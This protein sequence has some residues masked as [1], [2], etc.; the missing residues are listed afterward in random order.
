MTSENQQGPSETELLQAWLSSRDVPCPV[1]GY[2]LR[3]IEV[4]NCPECGAKLD[5]RVGSTDLKIG[6]WLVG[7]ISLTLPMGLSGFFAIYGLLMVL[8]GARGG[9]ALVT[10]LIA[11]GILA[12]PFVVYALLLRRLIRRRKEFW[13]KPRK[14]QKVSAVLY[15][16]AGSAPVTIPIAIWLVGA[17]LR[18]A[19]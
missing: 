7:V 19:G 9:A 16:L 13:S 12:A 15:I 17:L 2:N 6:L 5:L 11:V 8:S 10:Y 18:Y 4:A 14:A 3:S 1:C